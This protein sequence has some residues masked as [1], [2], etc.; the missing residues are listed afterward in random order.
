MWANLLS[1]SIGAVIGIIGA[2]VAAVWTVERA[3]RAEQEAARRE[4]ALRV[5]GELAAALVEFYDDLKQLISSGAEPESVLAVDGVANAAATL[6]RAITV[7]GPLLDADR[8]RRLGRLRRDIADVMLDRDATAAR[9]ELEAL[10]KEVRE[11][12]DDLRDLRR[13][14]FQSAPAGM[15]LTR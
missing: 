10:L 14:Q 9:S 2:V 6:R 4:H 3:R 8:E 7:D 1:G 12:G 13:R 5:S 15:R 11:V